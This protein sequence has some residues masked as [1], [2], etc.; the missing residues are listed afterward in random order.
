MARVQL[1]STSFN[2]APPRPIVLFFGA[3]TSLWVRLFLPNRTYDLRSAPVPFF[4]LATLQ[5]SPISKET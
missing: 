3:V 4:S 2:I 1:V 5:Q